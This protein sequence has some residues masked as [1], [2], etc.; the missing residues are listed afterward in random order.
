MTA[1]NA[2]NAAITV[3]NIALSFHRAAAAVTRRVLEAH[4]H[5]VEGVEAPHEQLF[6]LQAEGRLDVLVSA[7]LPASHQAYLAPYRDRAEVLTPHYHPYCVWAVPPYVPAGAVR[8]VADLARPEVAARMTRAID[9]INPGAGISR[10]SARM[11]AAYGLDRA[12]YTFTPGTEAGFLARVE[13]GLADR[14]W[15]VV[16]LWRPQYLNR[17]HGLRALSEPLGLLGGVDAASPVVHRTA[18][19]RLHPAALARLDALHLGNDGV[20]ELDAWI[21]AD[22]LT[23]LAAADRYLAAHPDLLH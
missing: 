12:G 5:R 10:F 7:W 18:L 20:E 8:E 21:N 16:P 22:G 11:V 23:P 19:E 14:E 4:G 3:G 9:G 13:Q 15:F 2:P 1:K 6:R 17:R